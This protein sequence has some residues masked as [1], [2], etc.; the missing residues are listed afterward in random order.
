MGVPLATHPVHPFIRRIGVQT[1]D[2]SNK[3]D[4]S[5]E[6][7][8]GLRGAEVM[9]AFEEKFGQFAFDDAGIGTGASLGE[10]MAGEVAPEALKQVG[11]EMGGGDLEFS[12][13]VT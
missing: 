7:H 13:C 3:G 5:R 2:L 8:R 12:D 4:G 6:R 9:G 10:W 11:E 1:Q